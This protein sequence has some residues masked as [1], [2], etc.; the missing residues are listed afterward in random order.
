MNLNPALFEAT[1][2]VCERTHFVSDMRFRSLTVNIVL[3]AY[4]HLVA[5][6]AQPESAA[7][8]EHSRLLNLAQ[9]QQPA[10]E[11]ARL[12][13]SASGNCDLCVMHAEYHVWNFARASISRACKLS[14]SLQPVLLP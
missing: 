13:F 4:V 6:H 2:K 1:A 3:C 9:T 7:T 12:R 5:A 14:I 10:V 11:L 8:F